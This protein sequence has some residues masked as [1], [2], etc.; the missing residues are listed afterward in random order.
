[1][2]SK[3]KYLFLTVSPCPCLMSSAW[4][5]CTSP[6]KHFSV[7]ELQSPPINKCC[8]FQISWSADFETV[9]LKNG[10]SG[11]CAWPSSLLSYVAVKTF[12]LRGQI[13]TITT[14]IKNIKICRST[15]FLFLKK[16]QSTFLRIKICNALKGCTLSCLCLRITYKCWPFVPWRLQSRIP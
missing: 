10:R 6:T 7:L 4:V 2:N 8:V 11:P 3:G 5:M 1:M 15:T 16:R 14:E 9:E 13:L 12:L